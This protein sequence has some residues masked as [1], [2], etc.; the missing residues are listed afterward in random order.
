MN[1]LQKT[2]LTSAIIASTTVGALAQNRYRYDS[3][4]KRTPEQIIDAVGSS[5]DD[6]EEQKGSTLAIIGKFNNSSN[7]EDQEI[8][9]I[10]KDG[11]MMQTREN[12][13]KI[14]PVTLQDVNKKYIQPTILKLSLDDKLLNQK[15]ETEYYDSKKHKFKTKKI[16][17]FIPLAARTIDLN[18]DGLD[19]I[20]VKIIDIKDINA[21]ET[22]STNTEQMLNEIR[23]Y[24]QILI[25][26]GNNNFIGTNTMKIVTVGNVFVKDSYKDS[27]SEKRT[28]TI[29]KSINTYGRTYAIG[30]S[31]KGIFYK[32]NNK[33]SSMED[34]IKVDQT[35]LMTIQKVD[36]IT[37]E[38]KTLT[39]ISNVIEDY[40]I[41]IDTTVESNTSIHGTKKGDYIV[42]AINTIDINGDKLD[43]IIV[44][45][46]DVSD[47]RKYFGEDQSEKTARRI[48]NTKKNIY[49][50]KEDGL[51][52]LIEIRFIF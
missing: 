4:D 49:L 12:E 1:T 52:E 6:E 17:R 38:T 40:L 50:N 47:T 29:I 39:E 14:Y 37:H 7:P 32:A 21:Y 41:G 45:I 26:T 25:S 9:L 23:T 13:N 22:I 35:G 44:D 5:N 42:T 18:N 30:L 36:S 19:D 43:D 24:T 16:S 34:I 31:K 33:N 3:E 28:S 20:L 15:M 10:R 48:S 8:I 46:T 51:F 2:I 11:S 27:P